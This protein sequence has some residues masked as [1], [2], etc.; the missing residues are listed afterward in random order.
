[1]SYEVLQL[2]LFTNDI[3]RVRPIEKIV[4]PLGWRLIAAVMQKQPVQ[5]ILEQKVEL[6][7]LDLELQNSTQLIS[8]LLRCAPSTPI[9][10]VTSENSIDKI[11]DA[12][13]M[14][15]KDF[16]TYPVN[17]KRLM[18]ALHSAIGERSTTV[19]NIIPIFDE[20]TPSKP[21]N[22]YL[23]DIGLA[24]SMPAHRKRAKD[25][26]DVNEQFVLDEIEAET[27]EAEAVEFEDA[28][29]EI[30][31][32]RVPITENAIAENLLENDSI[33]TLSVNPDA[34]DELT[35][36]SPNTHQ[37]EPALVQQT[38]SAESKL[39]QQSASVQPAQMRKVVDIVEDHQMQ[40]AITPQA[41]TADLD[42]VNSKLPQVEYATS[43]ST[44][45]EDNYEI[46]GGNGQQH[47]NGVTRSPSSSPVHAPSM[48]PQQVMGVATSMPTPQGK[49]T[50]VVSL[51]GGIGRST[52]AT[53]LAVAVAQRGHGN[54][55]LVEA[56]HGLSNLSLML[57]LHPQ[58]TLATLENEHTIDHD[59]VRGYLQQHTSGVNI[60]AAPTEIDD[61]IELAP[62]TWNHL[63]NITSGLAYHT[64][65]DTSSS[66]DSA[67]TEVLIKADEILVVTDPDIASLRSATAL[68]K[69]IY[70][71]PS[72]SGQ[73]RLVINR[74]GINGGLDEK[75]IQKQI[76][77]EAIV[78]LPYDPALTTYAMNRGI[79]FVQSHP[80]ALL[81]KRIQELAE[82]IFEPDGM[83]GQ[84]M[85]KKPATKSSIMSFLG[86]S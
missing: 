37:A 35:H 81:T 38:V 19:S 23:K 59:I 48:P 22:G 47:L 8:S 5:W 14:G 71:E 86:R 27:Y 82:K 10:A 57:H 54:V 15:A 6:I 1:M 58:R 7:L 61:M 34:P 28:I 46:A 11:H 44:A 51:R 25:I 74:S 53:N 31:R 50:A 39:V 24:T 30:A 12:I 33:S 32:A 70:T 67:L 20:T 77:H 76:G 42:M 69:N 9:L 41:A 52:I 49:I 3:E 66:A 45:I 75:T 73:M 83:M 64:I 13:E 16:I 72:I 18:A 65:L 36:E 2:A 85:M 40:K 84:Q 62:E 63:L 21:Q 60:L 78:S 43:K 17:A 4:S 80:R 55:T 29:A 26:E 56:H 79:P 68:Y